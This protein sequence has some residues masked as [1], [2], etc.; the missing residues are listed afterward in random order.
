MYAA[1]TQR[2]VAREAVL[3]DGDV[4]APRGALLVGDDLPRRRAQV[5][6]QIC[7]LRVGEES[8]VGGHVQPRLLRRLDV[9]GVVTPPLRR[10][11]EYV[12]A[13]IVG[14]L[15][16]HHLGLLG[17]R[18]NLAL[19]APGVVH[20]APAARPVAGEAAERDRQ[21]VAARRRRRLGREEDVAHVRVRDPGALRDD[22]QDERG[23]QDAP[24]GALHPRMSSLI[25]P[26]RFT[27]IAT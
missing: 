3:L 5:A 16:V 17:E 6:D 10:P 2:T 9:V 7:E 21:L 4:G 23:D 12:L 1:R 25:G 13:E 20:A 24:P 11:V 27:M 18:R 19:L 22:E 14:A 26:P 8:A 15:H